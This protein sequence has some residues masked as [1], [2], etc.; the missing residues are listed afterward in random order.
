VYL[1]PPSVPGFENPA[2]V[3]IN[4]APGTIRPGPEDD[5]T[6][7]RVLDAIGK[8]PYRD[9]ETWK[10]R[11]RPPCPEAYLK[12]GHPVAP[13]PDGHFLDV[14]RHTR[15]FSGAMTFAVVRTVRDIWEHHFQRGLPWFFRDT[16][17][18]LEIIPRVESAN[19]W[20]GEGFIEFGFI[21]EDPQDPFADNF[22][23]V[24]HETG[25][26]ILKSV[27]GNPTE[28]KK[29]LTYRAHEEAGADLVALI[30]LLHF[31]ED[32]VGPVLRR[33]RGRL[34]G[35]NPFSL[36][37]EY[38]SRR[39][40][41]M[42]VNEEDWSSIEGP[43]NDYDTHGVSVVISGAVYD[44]LVA[45]YHQ[46]LRQR[47]AV[48]PARARR[49]LSR[50]RL[51]ADEEEFPRR[52]EAAA[53]EFVEALKEARD[54]LARLLALAWDR[55]SVEDFASAPM[56]FRHVITNLTEA[57]AQLSGGLYAGWIHDLFKERG[58]PPPVRR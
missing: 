42:L 26:L 7:I 52:F 57:D 44:L 19:A 55:T 5:Y 24:A 33:T 6:G 8:P 34:Y 48:P 14:K 38:R 39:Q 35:R 23:S 29:T 47:S 43:W 18:Y 10:A 13:G 56:A 37:G 21:D 27:I 15:A 30:A 1:Q 41:R 53:S 2:I 46:R 45:L 32:A 4:A 16:Y 17:K 31:D 40:A 36:I 49:R 11:W 54:Y 25:H 20:S 9:E 22:D 12:H 50:A 58:L 51:A 3:R 28:D